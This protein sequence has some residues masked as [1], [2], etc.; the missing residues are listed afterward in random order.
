MWAWRP[1]WSCDQDHLNKLSFPY[2]KESPYEIWVQLVK[3]FQRRRCLKMLTDGRTTDAGVTCILIAHFG[4]F[5]SG[6]LKIAYKRANKWPQGCMKQTRQTRIIKNDPQKKHR[7]G[8]VSTTITG[9]LKHASRYQ[10]QP[11]FWCGSRHI[12]VWFAWNISKLTWLSMKVTSYFI[13]SDNLIRYVP[14]WV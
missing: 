12:D 10:P 13:I 11:W 1:S 4:A 5:G 9:G 3:W 8:N 7:F 14:D 6:E 2:P